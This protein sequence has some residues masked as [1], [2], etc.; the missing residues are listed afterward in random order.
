MTETEARLDLPSL[1]GCR[2]DNRRD[3][4]TPYTAESY[5]IQYGVPAAV[6]EKCTEAAHHAAAKTMIAVYFRNNPE[7][8]EEAKNLL[9]LY[10][11]GEY[12]LDPEQAGTDGM[13]KKEV[14]KKIADEVGMSAMA[15]SEA[16]AANLSLP[17]EEDM[18]DDPFKE[19]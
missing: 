17:D 15:E 19:G 1:R 7:R 9:D 3:T 12:A 5:R 14:Y 6:A 18:D 13:S 10:P 2:P 11:E 16:P 4:A 8:L